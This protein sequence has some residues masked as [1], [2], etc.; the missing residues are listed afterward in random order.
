MDEHDAIAV[1]VEAGLDGDFRGRTR[2][3]NV[4]VLSREGWEAACKALGDEL[5][6]T[7]RRANLLVEGVELPETTGA[8]LAIGDVVLE[9]SGECAPCERM[10]EARP[11]LRD[12]LSTEWR[13]GVECRVLSG[14]TVRRG[15]PV[16][17]RAY[18]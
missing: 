10:E 18:A 15:D 7:T 1:S 17:L 11:G 2:G 8:R 4:T 14:G 12:A 6:W 16:E 3:R 5:A 9:V 13:A